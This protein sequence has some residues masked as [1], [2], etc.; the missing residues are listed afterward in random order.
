MAGAGAVGW[1][2][3]CRAALHDG[4]GELCL[5]L[6]AG[7]ETRVRCRALAGTTRTIALNYY[8]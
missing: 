5:A 1:S 7:G 4:A 2:D 3:P 8:Y 6:C